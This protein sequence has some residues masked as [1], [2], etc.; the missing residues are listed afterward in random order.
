MQVGADLALIMAE[1]ITHRIELCTPQ[2]YPEELVCDRVIVRDFSILLLG[3]IIMFASEIMFSI[4]QQLI[5]FAK[6]TLCHLLMLDKRP[7][8]HAT[9]T[10]NRSLAACLVSL[11]NIGIE[12]S[13]A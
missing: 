11:K 13:I 7:P 6:T 9:Y 2:P 3:I 1:E 8:V 4:E 5:R 12:R 10:S